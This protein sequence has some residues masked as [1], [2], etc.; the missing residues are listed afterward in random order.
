MDGS[1]MAV[2]SSKCA[3]VDEWNKQRYKMYDLGTLLCFVKIMLMKEGVFWDRC[4]SLA[5]VELRVDKE[6]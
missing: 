2:R 1:N 4:V 6:E 5:N 3:K